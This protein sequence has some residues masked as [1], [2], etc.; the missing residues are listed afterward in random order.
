[1]PGPLG[2]TV[3]L[4]NRGPPSA[5]LGPCPSLGHT[6]GAALERGPDP[7]PRPLGPEGP[8]APRTQ[9][10]PPAPRPKGPPGQTVGLT[11][12]GPPS[13]PGRGNLKI[14]MVH[15]LPGEAKEDARITQR[16]ER[17]QPAPPALL[18][19]IYDSGE[20]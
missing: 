12:R 1:M 13:A 16:R 4:T 3:G 11:N 2:Q 9:G 17:R 18:L 14:V 7:S 8:P 5:A 19:T 6:E 20:A 15:V 10:G